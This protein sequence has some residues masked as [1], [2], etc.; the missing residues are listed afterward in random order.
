MTL[1]CG[2]DVSDLQVKFYPYEKGGG[3]GA[4]SFEV[5]L[6]QELEV[7]AI[8]MGGGGRKQFYPLPVINDL[9]LT[10]WSAWCQYSVTGWGTR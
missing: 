7:L 6:T 8:L 1:T 9:S 3:G 10:S 5:V 4:T 2:E